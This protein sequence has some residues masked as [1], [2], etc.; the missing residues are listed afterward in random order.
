MINSIFNK[1]VYVKIYENS[2]TIKLIAD[3]EKPI[4]LNAHEPF[5]TKRLLVGQFSVAERLLKEGINNLFSGKW[6]A[7]SPIVVIHPMDKIEGGLSEIEARV[8]RELAV[9]AGARKVVLWMGHEL[10]DDE[11]HKHSST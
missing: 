5:S 11:V 4:T 1:T 2:F 10:S 7:P 6:F 3:G 9:G 8:F